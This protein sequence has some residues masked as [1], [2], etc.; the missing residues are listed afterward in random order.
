M[1]L[2]NY[3]KKIVE[4]CK[5]SGSLILSVGMGLGKTAATLHYLDFA[6]KAFKAK[7]KKPQVLIVAPKR[8]AETVWR[9]EAKKWGLTSL[10]EEMVILAPP[11]KQIISMVKDNTHCIKIIGRDNIRCVEL[12][13]WDILV[14]D[15]LTSFKNPIAGRTC[16]IYNIHARQRIGLT[17]TFLVNGAIDIFGQLMAVGLQ[18]ATFRRNKKGEIWQCPEF[19]AWKCRHFVDVL[20]NSKLKFSKWKLTSPMEDIIEPIANNILTL[21]AEDYLDIPPVNYINR[22]V[23]LPAPEINNYTSMA[24]ELVFKDESGTLHAVDEEA[25]FM[26]LQ[27]IANG[28]IYDE[29]GKPIRGKRSTKLESV[30]ELVDRCLSE[31]NNCLLFYQF[32]EEARWLG[33][34]I[35]GNKTTDVAKFLEADKPTV[36]VTHPA[37]A[38]HGLNLQGNCHITIWS[39][40]PY[41]Y[42]LW[43]QGNA[44]VARQGQKNKAM[45][46][47]F[48]AAGTVEE[49]RVKALNDK[50]LQLNKFIEITHE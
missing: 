15:E 30:A 35:T 36:L 5:R 23:E 37:S 27:T 48:T 46:Y 20:E 16:C 19:E 31:G 2:H 8:V 47:Y 41:A 22:S 32:R 25:R 38:G 18:P 14:I 1:E 45:I 4:K 33:E 50:H 49:A 42:E 43:A 7:G 34:L 26:K 11:R 29:E 10:H 12:T 21:A 44:R 24:S 17:G 6:L 9:Q 28:F 3:Q 40:I 39:S 13:S